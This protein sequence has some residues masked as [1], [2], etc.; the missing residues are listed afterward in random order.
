M[1]PIS[2]DFGAFNIENGLAV[3]ADDCSILGDL[4]RSLF[5]VGDDGEVSEVP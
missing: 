2:P 4:P 1:H 3:T 5:V